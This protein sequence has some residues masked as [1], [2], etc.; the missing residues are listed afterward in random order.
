ML[1]KKVLGTVLTAA[2][3]VTTFAPLAKADTG[4]TDVKDADTFAS[5]VENLSGL[6]VMQGD[7]TGGTF[8]PTDKF[9]RAEAAK[10]L[11]V[12]TGYGKLTG[13]SKN[14]FTDV[15]STDWFNGV[16]NVANQVGLV[17]GY[18]KS[19]KKVFNPSGN[20]T[21]GEFA[22]MAVRALGYKDE[23][24][25]GDTWPYNYIAKATELGLFDNLDTVDAT[26]PATRADVA[27]VTNTLL[28]TPTK[29]EAAK[30]KPASLLDKVI[31]KLGLT[32]VTGTVYATSAQDS[33][34]A[35]GKVVVGGNTYDV[36]ASNISNYLGKTVTV[37]VNKKNALASVKSVNDAS[38]V[39]G[40]LKA[41]T[42]TVGTTVNTVPVKGLS[43]V[44]FNGVKKDS[45][46]TIP[47]G[48]TVT[49]VDANKDGSYDVAYAT[50]ANN[51][52]S[53][54]IVKSV[55]AT[56]KTVTFTDSTTV[57][58]ID[59]ATL[60]GDATKVADLKANDVLYV[61]ADN[62]AVAT[63]PT[64]EAIQVVRKT[65]TDKITSAASDKSWANIGTIKC[66]FTNK[67]FATDAFSKAYSYIIDKDGNV[68]G[69]YDPAT[70]T[71]TTVATATYSPSNFA[72][73]EGV[74]ASQSGLTTTYNYVFKLANGSEVTY[75]GDVNKIADSLKGSFGKVSLDTT[76]TPNKVSGFDTTAASV[77]A[78]NGSLVAFNNNIV[79]D[80]AVIVYQN[81]DGTLSTITGAQYK[82]SYN[83]ATPT[84]F[85]TGLQDSTTKFYP[86]VYAYFAKN[87]AAA[88]LT[89]KSSVADSAKYTVFINKADAVQVANDTD[90]SKATYTIKAFVDGAAKDL[91]ISGTAYDTLN[92]G[93]TVAN[94]VYYDASDATRVTSFTKPAVTSDTITAANASTVLV[95]GN[96]LQYADG[97]KV[98]LLGADLK[99]L[100]KTPA[101]LAGG[102]KVEY[103]KDPTSGNVLLAV[104]KKVVTVNFKVTVPSTT[105]ATDNVYIVGSFNGWAA[106][107]DPA[108]K[109]TRNADGTYSIT[110]D[111]VVGTEYK[112]VV[113]PS[114]S[115]DW[116]GVE[117]N[118]DGSELAA[119]RKVLETETGVMTVAKWA[120]K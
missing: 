21:Y 82:A 76:V 118:A 19:G 98:Y 31:S 55:D 69:Y 4:F 27:V 60:T 36:G 79:A 12:A 83:A 106:T 71:T 70:T 66:T 26:A 24:L 45:A 34:V 100:A 51:A 47:E 30:D 5:A 18:V 119:N 84:R 72:V 74:Y 65:V 9:T 87:G 111:L 14:V 88:G 61:T 90:R 56:A 46:F 2:M 78:L 120:N 40:T 114:K 6:G 48:S 67:A 10:V 32:T 39:T 75:P 105:V 20:V 54:K 25:S 53:G 17:Q 49:Y 103:I 64:V 80:N 77:D 116:S 104:A 109:L 15:A 101:D 63:A 44:Y 99:P 110:K 95:A 1:S 89:A 117:K 52:V 112:F 62:D 85:I 7:A 42:V 107:N 96:Y 23:D 16:V 41:G 102:M 59:A 93:Y 94:A 28:N 73:Y 113:N 13:S 91:K 29:A 38:V 115:D 58:Y 33:T 3:V 92:D 57:K 68:V 43:T 35:A 86:V 37:Y 97:A 8:R 22:T 11:V 81:A 50:L 108:N